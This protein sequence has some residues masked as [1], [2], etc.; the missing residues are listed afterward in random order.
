MPAKPEDIRLSS[1]LTVAGYRALELQQDRTA[2]SIFLKQRFT[3]RYISSLAQETNRKNGFAIVAL[4]CLMVEALESFE[5]GW[6]RSDRKSGLAFSGFFARYP[7]F[8]SLKPVAGE[9]YRHVRCGILH[10]A[11]STGGWRIRRDGEMFH[12][13]TLTI[14]AVKFMKGVEAALAAYCARLESEPWTSGTWRNFREK[15]AAVCQNALG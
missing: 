2:I 10:Q 8:A 15:M 11:E 3:E 12:S 9:F 6:A 13:P 7:Q 14:N 1:Q 5:N 4:A